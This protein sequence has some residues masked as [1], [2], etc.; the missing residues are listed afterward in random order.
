[1]QSG[2]SW[3][4]IMFEGTL[5]ALVTPFL[6]GNV[7][8]DALRA[9]VE[10]QIENGIHGLVVCGTTGEAAAM[11][12]DEQLN[13][14]RQTMEQSRQR[15]C[16]I[17]GTGSNNTQNTVE[18]TR[19]ASELKVD[20]ALVVTPY[21][22]KPP[23]RGLLEHYRRVAEVGL[24]VVAYNVPSRTGVC[25]TS[26]TVAELAKIKNMVGVKEASSDLKLG[27][28]MIKAAGERM[29]IISGDDQ[30]YLPL[31]ALGARG[32]IS[33]VGNLVPGPMSDLYN[34][35]KQG[36]LDQARSI[37]ERLLNLMDALFMETNPIPV[38]AA[39]AM[40]GLCGEEPRSPLASLHEDLKLRLKSALSECGLLGE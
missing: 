38:K 7:D 34:F 37:H 13:V 17:A 11:T 19:R 5:T 8:V 30:N 25:L 23:Q 3:R 36:H 27:S 16:V 32:C 21:Y 22:V 29:N 9:L 33:V 2:F 1:M 20:G 10:R 12:P 4:Q 6:N 28:Q 24:P 35:F 15:V 18:M 31:L 39:L 40:L 26:E 14:V